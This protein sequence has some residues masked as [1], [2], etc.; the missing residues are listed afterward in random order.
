MPF[1]VSQWGYSPDP[2][3]PD[4]APSGF[5]FGQLPPWRW[6]MKTTDALSPYEILNTGLVWEADSHTVSGARFLPIIAT[7]QFEFP[8]LSFSGS[9]LPSGGITIE[10]FCS[11]FNTGHPSGTFGFLNEL[12][13]KAIKTRSFTMLNT[14]VPP[15]SLIPNPLVITP[16]KWNLD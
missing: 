1:G 8:D 4:Y 7:P 5:D 13:P 10:W 16:R 14:G 15:P 11:F 12:Y 2:R 9:L 3:E 6:M